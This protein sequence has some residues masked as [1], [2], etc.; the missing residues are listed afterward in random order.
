M[1]KKKYANVNT[2]VSTKKRC[3]FTFN[4]NL[5]QLINNLTKA[6]LCESIVYSG[7]T[8]LSIHLQ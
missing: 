1:K 3:T 6:K 8:L 4:S 2:I 5:N 7:F